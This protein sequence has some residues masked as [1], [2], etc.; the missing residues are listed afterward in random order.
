MPKAPNQRNNH[1]GVMH[2]NL[3]FSWT[4]DFVIDNFSR[5]RKRLSGVEHEFV[6]ASFSPSSSHTVTMKPA[7]RVRSSR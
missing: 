1:A 5:F 7:W 6:A 4:F 3:F 2:L